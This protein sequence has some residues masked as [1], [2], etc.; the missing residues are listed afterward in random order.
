MSS[1]EKLIDLWSLREIYRKQARRTRRYSEDLCEDLASE[2]LTLALENERARGIAPQK[3]TVKWL[4]ASARSRVLGN[5][6][7][8]EFGYCEFMK[9]PIVRVMNDEDFEEWLSANWL[10]F[11][12]GNNGN[13]RAIAR[14]LVSANGVELCFDARDLTEL[15][16]GGAKLSDAQ[17]VNNFLRRGRTMWCMEG[18]LYKTLSHAKKE[19][20]LRPAE[21]CPGFEVTITGRKLDSAASTRGRVGDIVRAL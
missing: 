8:T 15:L 2:M 6:K 12:A 5:W 16:R 20:G 7:W 13:G 21:S 4:L 3:N 10:S 9:K 19:L 11:S 18:R 14:Y 1:S 17:V